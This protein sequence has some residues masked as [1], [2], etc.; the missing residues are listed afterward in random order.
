MIEGSRAAFDV[1]VY[2][3]GSLP[4]QSARAVPKAWSDYLLAAVPF[5]RR[6][7]DWQTYLSSKQFDN[8]VARRLNG[9]EIFQGV[10]G[11]CLTSLETAR[12]K[13]ARTL[14]DVITTHIDDF[15]EHQDRECA[16]FKIRPAI[17]P[18]LRKRM[19]QEYAR[20]DLIRVMSEYARQ[21]FMARGFAQERV[22]VVSPPI[23]FEKFTAAQ[24]TEPKFRVSFVGLIEP[25]KGFHYLIDA[26]NGL[27]IPDSELV[28]WGGSGTRSVSRYLSREMAR[29]SRIVLKS[30]EVRSYGY[31][32]VYGKSSVFV[33][34][35]LA[36]GFGYGVA[37]AM[38]SGLPV[39]VTRNTG[40]AEFVIDGQNGYVVP[41]ADSEAIRDRLEHLAKNPALLRKMGQAA[42]ETARSLTFEKFRD[43]YVSCLN[44]LE[45]KS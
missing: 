10:T 32:E 39:I 38:A 2:C 37:E 20:A 21:T 44:S 40:A 22:K 28:L 4:G 12:T 7:R 1:C 18:L 27:E 34:P 19:R 11:Q 25:W 24:F 9:A 23:D 35:S 8:Y 15:G 31:G 17:H 13:G 30:V 42:R 45:A 33:H 36:D 43:R 14:L 3:R 16:K 26:F 41:A 29:N 5:V 6:L